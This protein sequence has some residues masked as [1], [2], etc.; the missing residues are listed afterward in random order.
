MQARIITS[1]KA[2]HLTDKLFQPHLKTLPEAISSVPER[3][4][5]MIENPKE[6][7][8]SP[9]VDAVTVGKIIFEHRKKKGLSMEVLS[10]LSD[11]GRTALSVI[12]KGGK[13]PTYR[14]F[15]RICEALEI[16]H[17]D[18]LSEIEGRLSE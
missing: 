7:Y 4:I 12:E 14:V 8:E 3:V 18:M 16:K 6:F 5:N 13:K 1:L 11:I 2:P 9:D 10:G 15:K 17:L